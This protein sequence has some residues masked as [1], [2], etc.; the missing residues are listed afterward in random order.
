[1]SKMVLTV[2]LAMLA[3]AKASPAFQERI[4]PLVTSYIQGVPVP[5]IP[6]RV[7]S[8]GT[9]KLD[10]DGNHRLAAARLAGI[11]TVLVSLDE[12]DVHRL[13]PGTVST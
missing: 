8:G 9:L 1:M 12:R 2:P 4:R 13:P 11:E 5:P 10:R 6:V 3:A 7:S